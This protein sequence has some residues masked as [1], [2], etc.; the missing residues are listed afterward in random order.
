MAF[1][2]DDAAGE[3]S[4]LFISWKSLHDFN[5]FLDKGFVILLREVFCCQN[6]ILSTWALE[7]V[8]WVKGSGYSRIDSDEGA[9]INLDFF[10]LVG[11]V[12]IWAFACISHGDQGG[13]CK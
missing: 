4:S 8:R 10:S 7:N 1:K 9:V 13:Y 11:T 6:F 2:S 5:N 3:G 12:A